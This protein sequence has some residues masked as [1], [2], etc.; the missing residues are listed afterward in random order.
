MDG[1][2]SRTEA[3]LGTDAL[4]K[5][6]NAR[7][8]VFGVGG[9]GGY[10]AEALARCGVGCIDIIDKD[11]IGITNINRQIYALNSTVGRFKT[12]VAKARMLDIN[13]DITV[14]TYKTFY[15]PENADDFDLSFYDYVVDAVDTVTAKL[16]L[17]QRAEKC[18]TPI[19]SSMG[20]GNKV[21]PELFEVADIYDTSVCPLAKVMRC[22][23]RKRGVK[24]LKVVYSKETPKNDGRRTPMSCSFVPGV[25]GLII[26]GEVVKDIC[27]HK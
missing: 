3:L 15:L 10:T 14:N 6:K 7:I 8:A 24:K 18:G 1:L 16:E 5:L 23:L 9:V 26:A 17:A 20:T 12:D 13:P 2:F 19:I 22:E 21:C 27:K 25:A 4:E 11:T